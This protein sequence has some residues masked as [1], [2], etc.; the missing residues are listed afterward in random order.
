MALTSLQYFWFLAVVVVLHWTL[1]PRWRRHLLLAASLGFY[2]T[3]G[4]APL[5]ALTIDIAVV[6]VATD[7]I[8][9]SAGRQKAAWTALGVGVPLLTLLGDKALPGGSAAP[10]PD[11]GG[12]AGGFLAT[13][14]ISF[15]TFHAISYVLDCRDGL[16][17]PEQSALDR[18]LYIAFF[19]H[20]LA[21]PIMRARRLIPLFHL[22]LERPPPKRL[23]EAA[24]MLVTGVF[25]KVVLA[26]PVLLASAE[27]LERI[28]SIST[29]TMAIVL[30]VVVV[31]GYFNVLGYMYLA[32]GSAR[33]LGI[34]MQP[35]TVQPFTRASGLTD[36]WR[37]MQVTVMAWFR[38]YIYA[39]I[40]GHQAGA[41]WR[42]D[43]ALV[44]TMVLVGFWHGISLQWLLWGVFTAAILIVERRIPWLGHHRGRRA[45]VRG[46]L[47]AAARRVYVFLLIITM[48]IMGWTEDI[49]AGEVVDALLARRG[50]PVDTD[51]VVLLGLMLVALVVIDRRDRV[52]V[53]E[54]DGTSDPFTVTRTIGFGLMILLIIIHLGAEAQPFWY[55]QY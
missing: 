9:R 44:V 25:L 34:R 37:R 46:A 15:F 29:L 18:A 24:E 1:R 12:S 43:V 20:L 11:L 42:G 39:P 50:G 35:N 10:I 4:L 49:G 19:P 13:V 32:L 7:R 33:L 38:D 30:V 47:G 45:G 48:G 23:Q 54:R 52:L 2:A 21:G 6:I 5:A 14:G 53:E 31:A 3:F 55:A 51:L 27:R 8:P 41:E 22:D 36:F 26:D 40:R 17:P 28:G 16:V